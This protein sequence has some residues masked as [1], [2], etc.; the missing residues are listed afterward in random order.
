MSLSSK[1]LFYKLNILLKFPE[2]CCIIKK[3]W[4][5]Q[6]S[7]RLLNGVYTGGYALTF[8][9]AGRNAESMKGGMLMKS[10]HCTY[11]KKA[12]YCSFNYCGL[13][14]NFCSKGNIAALLTQGQLL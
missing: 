2:F 6:R 7:A 11:G 14:D 3:R 4:T 5:I 13:R 9:F 1:S 12:D 10:K 8:I